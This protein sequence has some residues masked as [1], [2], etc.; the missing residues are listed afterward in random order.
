ME[1][2]PCTSAPEFHVRTC[3]VSDF[4][5]WKHVDPSVCGLA[6]QIHPPGPCVPHLNKFLSQRSS[7]GLSFAYDPIVWGLGR[8]VIMLMTVSSEQLDWETCFT[9]RIRGHV[10]GE[11]SMHLTSTCRASALVSLERL[12]NWRGSSA[13]RDLIP[14]VPGSVATVACDSPHEHLHR[15]TKTVKTHSNS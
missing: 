10:T 8:D 12:S 6:P 7:S 9:A 14:C 1:A 2:R 13:L 3:R 15:S 11:L 4:C 5:S